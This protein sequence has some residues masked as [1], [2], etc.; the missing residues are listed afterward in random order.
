MTVLILLVAQM[1]VTS[2][3]NRTVSENLLS[4]LQNSYGTRSGFHRAMIHLQMDS[5]RA[6]TVDALTERWAAPLAFEMG[7]ASVRV[8]VHDSERGLNLTQLASGK[9]AHPAVAAQLRRLARIL[10]HPPDS[11]ERIIDYID[12]NAKGE[13]EM[14]ARN[15]PLYNIEELLRIE[16]LKPEIL[17]GTHAEGQARKGLLE[18]LTLWPQ[19]TAKGASLPAPQINVNTAPSEI[20]QSLSDGMTPGIAEAIVARRS[21]QTPEG[22]PRH[23]QTTAELAEITAIPREVLAEITPQVSVRSSTFEIRVR[24]QAGT[25]ERAWVYVVRR[26]ASKEQALKLVASQRQ[27]DLLTVHPPGEEER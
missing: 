21:E 2:T 13:F 15:A 7:R 5:E 24:S 19:E 25:L 1:T 8:T 17:Y 10:G 16:G 6:A 4:D 20:L 12:A 3:H 22:R 23:F 27:N 14:G 26:E 18:F 11:A 9:E